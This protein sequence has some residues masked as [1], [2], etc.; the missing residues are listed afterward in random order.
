MPRP[1]PAE[2]P[3]LDDAVSVVERDVRATLGDAEGLRLVTSRGEVFVALRDGRFHGDPVRVRPGDTAA[4]I[5][6]VVAEAAQDTVMG[7][8]WKAWPECPVHHTVAGVARRGEGSRTTVDADHFSGAPIATTGTAS[9]LRPT[10]STYPPRSPGFPGAT[11]GLDR[12]DDK[13]EGKNLTTDMSLA[14]L[15]LVM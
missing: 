11:A 12:G 5:I 8:L 13:L 3:L 14:V 9:P 10:E 7:V 1:A 15:A 2:H 4:T 6:A